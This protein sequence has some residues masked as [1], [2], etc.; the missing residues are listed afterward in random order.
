[1]EIKEIAFTCCAV[2]DMSRARA[3]YEGVFGLKPN[4]PVGRDPCCIEYNVDAGTFA[5]ES[6]PDWPVPLTACP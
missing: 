5:I 3:F 6:N 2:S 4:A 1:M